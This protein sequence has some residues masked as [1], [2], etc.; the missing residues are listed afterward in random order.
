MG[1]LSSNEVAKLRSEANMLDKLANFA[2]DLASK[3]EKDQAK[4]LKKKKNEEVKKVLMNELGIPA[5]FVDQLSLLVKA[6]PDALREG[7]DVYRAEAKRRREEADYSLGQIQKFEKEIKEL[8]DI[9]QNL[10][11][12]K[13]EQNTSHQEHINQKVYELMLRSNAELELKE[14]L[15]AMEGRA[16]AQV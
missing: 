16:T 15:A 8:N 5:E 6:G 2:D 10:R 13:E 3:L 9:K 4:N 11:A 1:D 7:A 14:A 12:Q